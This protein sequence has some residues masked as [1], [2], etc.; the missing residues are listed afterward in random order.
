MVF[1]GAAHGG[2]QILCCCVFPRCRS[3][4]RG[5]TLALGLLLPAGGL[6]LAVFYL[7]PWEARYE[8]RDNIPAFYWEG[9]SKEAHNTVISLAST[10]GL[11]Y[12]VVW[13]SVIF[14]GLFSSLP[15]SFRQQ[16]RSVYIGG[17]F[18]IILLIFF[19]RLH[20]LW[21]FGPVIFFL[22]LIGFPIYTA[23]MF[24]FAC[25]GALMEVFHKGPTPSISLQSCFYMPCS[26]NSISELDQA[27]ALF[28]GLVLFVAGEVV[29]PVYA[30][31][32]R[33]HAE[34]RDLEL[35]V[36]QRFSVGGRAIAGSVSRQGDD[37]DT[38]FN[39]ARRVNSGIMA[40]EGR[41][42]VPERVARTDPHAAESGR[43]YV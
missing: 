25:L 9:M 12:L 28:V 30:R 1:W 33:A 17:C 8:I 43:V 26:R 31:F 36:L 11:W 5:V 4:Q 27:G 6:A 10:A 18:V 40:E 14:L 20:F 42:P 22:F 32:K 2:M 35:Q 29:L 16:C 38:G 24:A 37:S 23:F 21:V 19:G 7:H 34:E 41:S 13:C 15:T 3:W 39:A